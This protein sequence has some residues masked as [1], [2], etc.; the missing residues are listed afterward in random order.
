MSMRFALVDRTRMGG[1]SFGV[2]LWWNMLVESAG[3]RLVAS[4]TPT[5]NAFEQA[6]SVCQHRKRPTRLN[7]VHHDARS[8]LRYRA[9]RIEHALGE[10]RERFHAR[11]CDDHHERV[12]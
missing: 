2:P 9:I 12:I 3:W 1:R 6:Q 11:E 10:S 4:A 8:E 7:A 5:L